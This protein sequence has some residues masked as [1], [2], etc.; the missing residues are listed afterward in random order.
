MNIIQLRDVSF[1][2]SEDPVLQH[3]NMQVEPGEFS[4]IIGS[5]GAGKSTLVQLILKELTPHH[6]EIFLFGQPLS[7]F[8]SWE[9]IGYVPQNG[10][11]KHAHFPAT[12]FEIVASNLYHEVGLFR[13]LQ[14]Q[15]RARVREAL[16]M[17]GMERFES[18]MISD[19]SGGQQQRV[20]LARA[21]VN[22]P[23]L[24]LLDEPT[25]GVDRKSVRQFFSLLTELNRTEHLSIVMVTHDL[26]KIAPSLDSAFCLEESYLVKLE[27]EDLMHELSH[28]HAHPP[29]REREED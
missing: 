26:Q 9:K 22:R 19:L 5:N 14:P 13:R 17:V 27:K 16:E 23:S 3:V 7:T 10:L 1:K 6:G 18:R 24:M 2:Y 11:A 4:A 28:R 25:T 29:L 21:L 12:A 20:L 8:H 15:H